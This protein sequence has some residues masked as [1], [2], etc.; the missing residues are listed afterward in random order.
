MRKDI[1]RLAKK[2]IEPCNRKSTV[3]VVDADV[4]DIISVIM[5]ADH[6]SKNATKDFVRFVKGKTDM[7]TLR[8]IY[9]FVRRTIRYERDEEGH[10]VVN[11][12]GCTV[13]YSKGDCKSMSVLT[14]SI[15]R[16]L[17]Y[18]FK[19]RTAFY[20]PDE[21]QQGH[22][23][24]VVDL[25]GK[26]VIV[27]PVHWRFNTEEPYWRVDDYPVTSGAGL[28]GISRRPWGWME[29]GIAAAIGVAI[30]KIA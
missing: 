21:P 22:I 5:H 4:D 27:D 14:G 29:W 2:H 19:Y 10:E 9:T 8:N 25:N 6:Y 16:D 24:A 1:A 7:E 30:I 18:R 11:T 17:G 20:D 26:E 13:Y 15:L 23:Y 3:M 28:S 12:P